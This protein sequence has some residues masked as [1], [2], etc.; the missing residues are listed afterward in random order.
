MKR[1]AVT[2][3]QS[4]TFNP[5]P[6]NAVV[7]GAAPGGWMTTPPTSLPGGGKLGPGERGGR[8]PDHEARRCQ[9][10]TSE[11]LHAS[12]PLFVIRQPRKTTLSAYPPQ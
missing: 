12:R 8:Q 4:V 11:L 6:V 1:A 9:R 3:I 2:T 10:N 5:D 7:P